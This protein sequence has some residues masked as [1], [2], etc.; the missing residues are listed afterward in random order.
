MIKGKEYQPK[1]ISHNPDYL[2]DQLE[3]LEKPMG[4]PS[5]DRDLCVSKIIEYKEKGI[6]TKEQ[7][8]RIQKI[9]NDYFDDGDIF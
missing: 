1:N 9:Y 5:M 4:D 2:I 7:E 8:E 3:Q 6:L